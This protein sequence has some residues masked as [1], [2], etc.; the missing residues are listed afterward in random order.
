[1]TEGPRRTPRPNGPW[2]QDDDA[3]DDS[4]LLG[5]TDMRDSPRDTTKPVRSG[6]SMPISPRPRRRRN[7]TRPPFSCT[8][9]HPRQRRVSAA[10]MIDSLCSRTGAHPFKRA[11][12]LRSRLGRAAMGS[13]PAF[14]R[15][16]ERIA[17][18]LRPHRSP[19]FEARR[20]ESGKPR[21][22]GRS[23]ASVVR[24][25]GTPGGDWV[26]AF[27]PPGVVRVRGATRPLPT[28]LAKPG[29]S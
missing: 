2:P 22:T 27:L 5:L 8:C 26:P 19:V 11:R 4:A 24:K 20:V 14:F 1:M 13:E 17:A 21:F 25:V 18:R 12:Q 9:S 16:I 28:A 6:C 7:R 3:D 29:A 23:P 15:T 10:S